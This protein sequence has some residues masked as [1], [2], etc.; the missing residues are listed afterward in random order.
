[1]P[2]IY[3]LRG[4]VKYYDWGGTSFIPSLLQMGNDENL[5]FAEYWMGTHPLGISIVE[6]TDGKLVPLRELAGNLPYLFKVQE[7]KK[8]LSIQVHPS[9][10]AAEIEFARENAEDI[11]LDAPDRNYKDDNHK[12]EMLVALGNFWLLHGFKPDNELKDILTNVTELKVLL[13]LFN[14]SGYAG[15]Y[16]YVMELPQEEVNSM[17]QPLVDKIVPI[18]KKGQLKKTSENF[19]AARAALTFLND[20]NIDRGIFSIYLFNIVHL[21]KGEGIFQ[22]AGVPHA[23]LEGH[24]V[25]LMANSDNVLRGGLT[26]KHVDVKEL[27]KHVKCEATYPLIIYG[28]KKSGEEIVYNTPAP[29]FR[30]SVFELE[31]GE[32]TGFSPLSVE[33][34]LLTEGVI[35]LDDDNIAIKLQQGNPSAVV[36]P[37]QPVYLAAAAKSTIFRASMPVNSGE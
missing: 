6:M 2:G 5:P 35:E 27:L 33:I 29:D 8:M 30:L 28:E 37:G 23:Y 19:W 1:M 14:E 10:E 21:K 9:K 12:P 11:P 26:S 31:A 3:P 16:K 24:N 15:L 20:H 25:E 34:L 13:P 7:V 17:L 4:I 18:Y 36:L 22:A 32:T